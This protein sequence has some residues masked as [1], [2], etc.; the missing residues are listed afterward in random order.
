[1][2]LNRYALYLLVALSMSACS[3][4][5]EPQADTKPP[6][7]AAQAAADTPSSTDAQNAQNTAP[8][9]DVNAKA[10]AADEAPTSEPAAQDD[11]AF[12][13]L[14]EL[15]AQAMEKELLKPFEAT[16]GADNALKALRERSDLGDDR[17]KEQFVKTVFSR[18][19]TDP[20][21]NAAVKYMTTIREYKDPDVIYQRAV[22]EYSRRLTDPDAGARAMQFFKMA[23]DLNH[24]PT[25]RFLIQNPSLGLLDIALKKI[26]EIFKKKPQTPENKFD[27]AKL[28]EM[29]PPE[30]IP[31][32]ESLI[33][34]AS[35]AGYPKAMYVHSGHLM[36]SENTWLQGFELLQKAAAAGSDDANLRLAFFYIAIAFTN[37]RD[38]ASEFIAMP[39]SEIQYNSIKN[40]VD[41][42]ADKKLFCV[43]TLKKAS[44]IEETCRMLLGFA[45]EP[46]PTL[47]QLEAANAS[48]T[49]LKDFIDAMPT[50]DACDHAYDLATYAFEDEIS[51]ADLTNI[52]TEPQRTKLGNIMIDCYKKALA[53]GDDYPIERPYITFSTAFQLA[54]L[55][56]GNPVLNIRTQNIERLRY[57]VYAAHH[58]DLTAQTTLAI[59]YEYGGDIPKNPERK[60]LWY[61]M[62]ASHHVCQLFCPA[63][64]SDEDFA[65]TCQPCN[66]AKTALAQCPKPP[67]P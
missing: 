34:A 32:I 46:T 65:S 19:K 40:I 13:K 50:R 44:G 8:N 9:A 54:V 51:E 28:L 3:K 36:D 14:I 42:A 27:L 55:Y 11:E 23:A 20:N 43:E 67:Q 16:E 52:F 61:A 38:E 25:L 35:D 17:A 2:R 64:Q 5:A 63:H 58:N 49:C 21:Y 22:Y 53:N 57:L 48:V 10:P 4:K 1:M 12:K 6:V 33:S 31:Q 24:E 47:A 62:A 60:C 56:A 15:D 7:E 41:K 45:A 29:G 59:N 30:L 26:V 39:L 37:S 66:V 18:P